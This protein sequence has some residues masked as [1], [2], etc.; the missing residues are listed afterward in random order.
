MSIHW[1]GRGIGHNSRRPASPS[2]GAV[3]GPGGDGSPVGL[4][5]ALTFTTPLPGGPDGSM[6]FSFDTQSG[7]IALLEDI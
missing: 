6:D 5:L 7:L 3:P 4:L 1:G 2:A